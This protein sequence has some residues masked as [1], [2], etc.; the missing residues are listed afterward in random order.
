MRI[1]RNK[2]PKLHRYLALSG[3]HAAGAA[4]FSWRAFAS[5]GSG[6]IVVPIAYGIAAAGFASFAVAFMLSIRA[7]HA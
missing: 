2:T 7:R 4:A 1:K 6:N 3:M 5:L